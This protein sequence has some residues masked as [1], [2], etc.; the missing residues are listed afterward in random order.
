MLENSDSDMFI[1][2]PCL[3]VLRCLV[4]SETEEGGICRRFMPAMYVEGEEP[5]RKYAELKS[6]YLK[7]KTRV[8]GGAEFIIKR[9]GSSHGSRQHSQ[10]RDA[11]AMIPN[12][13]KATIASSIV[14]HQTGAIPANPSLAASCNKRHSTPIQD[15][16]DDLERLVLGE[17]PDMKPKSQGN[18]EAFQRVLLLIR[19]LGMELQRCHPAD[20]N[21][22]M[23][24]ACAGCN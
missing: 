18:E 4:L 19:H 9:G 3:S 16:H 23:S 22:F 15:F 12:G 24:A 6:E 11:T 17:S 1:A 2:V 13:S 20:W 5:Q 7:L 21:E 10:S 14:P 8:C